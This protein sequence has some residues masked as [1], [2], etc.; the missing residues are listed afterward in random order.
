[1]EWRSAE[2]NADRLPGLATEL[3]PLKVDLIVTAG[4]PV[5]RSAKEVTS[6]I[7]ILMALGPDLVGNGFVASLARR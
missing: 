6:T 7:P 2:G 5:S 3:A 4:S 1:M